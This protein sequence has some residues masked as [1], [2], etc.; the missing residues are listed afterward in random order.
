MLGSLLSFCLSFL[1]TTT[2]VRL[3]NPFLQK[4]LEIAARSSPKLKIRPTDRFFLGLLT[5][6]PESWRD[7]TWT[8]YRSR[9][10]NGHIERLI[11]SIRHERLD[12]VV[13][14]NASHLRGILQ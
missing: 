7:A 1:R 5:D 14:L 6:L 4:L 13:V 8:A 2:Q 9:W 10:Q 12:H 11:G 3:E